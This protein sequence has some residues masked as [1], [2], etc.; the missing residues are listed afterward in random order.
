MN[1][2]LLVFALLGNLVCMAQYTPL[3]A[4]TMPTDGYVVTTQNDTIRG[5]VMISTLVNDSP[6]SVVVK[7]AGKE[8][9]KFKDDELQQIFQ[10]IPRFAYALGPSRRSAKRLFLNAYPTRDAMENSRC[11]N[12]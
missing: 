7:T 6:A 12:A 4:I 1:P 11:S 10:R 9:V 8:K 2:F 5:Q 3:G